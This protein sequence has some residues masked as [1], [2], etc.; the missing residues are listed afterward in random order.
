MA[1]ICKTMEDNPDQGCDDMLPGGTGEG[2]T[3]LAIIRSVAVGMPG[4]S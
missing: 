2:M 4:T 3:G 1:A